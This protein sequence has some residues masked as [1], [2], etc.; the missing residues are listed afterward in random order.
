[1]G[2]VGS[3]PR[4]HEHATCSYSEPDQSS[5]CPKSHFLKIHF[6]II[7]SS[8]WVFLEVSFFQD[9][10]PKHCI[11]FYS[12]PYMLHAPPISFFFIWSPE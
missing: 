3:L 6:N 9:F 5:P 12:P 1:M 8:A 4:L 2:P 11:H 7:V 10:P